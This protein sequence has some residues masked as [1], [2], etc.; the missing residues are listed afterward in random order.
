MEPSLTTTKT[1]ELG[2]LKRNLG[3]ELS[4]LCLGPLHGQRACSATGPS[5]EKPRLTE[6]AQA[7][8]APRWALYA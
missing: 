6:L 8:Q 7:L 2:R 4:L 5:M 3:A 1:Q